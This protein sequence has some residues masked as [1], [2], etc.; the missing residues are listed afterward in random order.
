MKGRDTYDPHYVFGNIVNM[1]HKQVDFLRD[2]VAKY[3]TSTP[4]YVCTI[5]DSHVKKNIGNMVNISPFCLSYLCAL[6]PCLTDL[7]M[8][9]HPKNHLCLC[10]TLTENSQ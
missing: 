3:K 2:Y 4:M 7:F 1:D 5:E 6:S 9:S 10:S 8:F